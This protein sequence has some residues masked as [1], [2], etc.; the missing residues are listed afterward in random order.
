MSDIDK[1]RILLIDDDARLCELVCQY[2]RPEG[3]QIE[4]VHT[5]ISGVERAL[6]GE[7]ALVVLDVMLPDLEGF[8]V[9]RRIRG[10]TAIP[11]LMLTARGED[12]DRILGLE[13]GADDYLPKPCNPRELAARMRA[14]LRRSRLARQAPRPAPPILIGDLELDPGAKIARKNG[15]DL[16]LT[17]VEFDLLHTLALAAGEVVSRDEITRRVLGREYS[18]FDRSI[19]VHVSNLRRKA[20]SLADGLERIKA[21]R[22]AGYLYVVPS[23]P[24]S[25]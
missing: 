13:I 18:P 4:A 21:V 24:R 25:E 16:S 3:F 11:V 15:K 19:E 5:G 2:L 20:G 17:A 9:L 6:S 22:G 10:Q 1:D 8:E 23:K 12:F 14:I 7:Y